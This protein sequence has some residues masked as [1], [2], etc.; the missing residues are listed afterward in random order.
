MRKILQSVG[1]WQKGIGKRA[2]SVLRSLHEILIR[3]VVGRLTSEANTFLS[4]HYITEG[5]T[6]PRWAATFGLWWKLLG[7]GEIHAAVVKAPS[8]VQVGLGEVVIFQ[9]PVLIWGFMCAKL[10]F[11]GACLVWVCLGIPTWDVG[12][13]CILRR[14]VINIKAWSMWSNFQ[15]TRSS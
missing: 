8:P 10:K 3:V 14:S 11:S 6:F 7:G 9:V 15:K 2:R 12:A 4:H 5:K 13:N 1:K